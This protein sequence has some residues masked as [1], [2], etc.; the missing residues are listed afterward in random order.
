MK[1]YLVIGKPISHS[2][3][4]KLHSQWIKQN[5]LDASY[6]KKQ[7][8]KEDLE[9]IVLQIRKD[10]LSGINITVPYKK[11]I[12]PYLD[13]LSEEAQATQSVNTV[14]KKNGKVLGYNT[15]IYGF[16]MAIKEAEF[17]L[18]NKKIHILG[19]GGVVPSIIYSLSKRNVSKIFI[20]NRTK[21]KAEQLKKLNPD[22]DLEIIKWNDFKEVDLII[23]ATSIGLD[24]NNEINIDH[25]KIGKNKLFYDVIYNPK[26]TTFLKD[27]K[28]LGNRI[29][30]GKL[31]FIYQAQEAFKL[32]HNIKPVV[33]K[34]IE[35]ILDD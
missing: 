26:L 17:D 21:E 14:L 31:M 7:V 9:N 4:P 24:K 28:S 23:N 12:I 30:N 27:A 19:A 25:N 33:N 29:V 32:W 8:Q 10:Y 34:H 22:I 5:N 20:S 2:L 18:T 16:T 1:K 3:S 35:D 13:N 6:D 11:D 15:D